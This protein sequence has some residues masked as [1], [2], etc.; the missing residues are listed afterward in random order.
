M[1][2]SVTN[3]ARLVQSGELVGLGVAGGEVLVG[4]VVDVADISVGARVATGVTVTDT[5]TTDVSGGSVA[6]STGVCPPPQAESMIPIR[7]IT[8]NSFLDILNLRC[9]QL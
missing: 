8:M 7:E 4:S 1:V 5:L 9:S 3:V 6:V 2:T